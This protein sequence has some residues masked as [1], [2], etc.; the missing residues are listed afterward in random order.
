MPEYTRR[1]ERLRGEAL[2]S[3]RGLSEGQQVLLDAL[4]GLRL[5]KERAAD[6]YRAVVQSLTEALTAR[7]GYT[8]EHSDEVQLLA[9]AVAERLGLDER[10]IAEAQAVAILHDIG[11]IGIPDRVL[12]KPGRLTGE[13]WELMRRHPEIGERILRPLPGLGGVARC[14][15]HEHERWDGDGYPDGLAGEAIPLASRIVLACDA[16]HALVSDRPYRRA[17]AA[18]AARAEL[19]RCAGTQFD[20]QV[21]DAL[22]ECLADDGLSTLAAERLSAGLPST[23]PQQQELG[24]LERE[25]QALLSIATAVAGSH[26]LHDVLDVT[27]EEALRALGTDSLS[28]SRLEAD[29]TI[30]RTLINAGELGPGEERQPDDEVYRLGEDDLL[31]QLLLDGKCYIG[32]IDDPDLYPMERSLL[33]QLGKRSCV[34]VP[35]MFG[36]VAWGELWAA[37]GADRPDFGPHDLRFLQAIAGQVATAI[38]RA[39]IFTRM[40]ELAL[41]DDLTG[42][43]NRRALDGRLE[44]AL[45][46]A[47]ETGTELAV[48][49]CDIDRLKELNDAH[50]H[51]AGDAALRHAA[52]ALRALTEGRPGT[53][54]ARLGGDEMC[55]L[56]E[57]TGPEAAQEL[58][59]SALAGLAAMTPAL[60]LSCGVATL[61]PGIERASDLLRAADSAL[62]LAKRSGRGRVCLA[63]ADPRRAWREAAA[64]RPRRRA[65]RETGR[66]DV[67]VLLADTLHVLDG[68]LA[69]ARPLDRL[70]TVMSACAA[71]VNGSAAAISVRPDGHGDLLTLLTHDRRSGHAARAEDGAEEERFRVADYPATAA[72]LGDGGSTLWRSDDETADA[73]ERALLLE[74]GMTA[75]LCSAVPGDEGAWLLEIYADDASDDLAALEPVFRVLTVH[76]LHG[77]GGSPL[78]RSRAI[79]AA[80][81]AI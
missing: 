66:L 46:A 2:A 80:A 10:E 64:H 3:A 71:A 11:K 15:R 8:S 21:V 49:L 57:D 70:E 32:V 37:R 67:A 60:G 74:W 12:H 1:L 18:D 43:A 55:V 35:I 59:Q 54:V 14:V 28:I 62:Y 42:L 17:L 58:A 63:A 51:Q 13:E 26:E 23:E 19:T 48:I 72:L 36:G 38:G 25:L 33:E 22:L 24:A 50:G 34:A 4:R 79:S 9:V 45:A 76:A 78:S 16:W 69:R 40:A 81:R 5:E 20:P 73:G 47:G 29:G 53:L 39:E 30:M 52:D 7:D 56:L 61:R 75:V 6:G 68:A 44:T 27:A 77:G 65:V 41:K 31:R